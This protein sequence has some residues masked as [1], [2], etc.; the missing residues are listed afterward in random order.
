[1]QGR[2]EI[3][4]RIPLKCFYKVNY[5]K[6]YNELYFLFT[7]YNP[8]ARSTIT[9]KTLPD[10]H[11][12]MKKKI[13]NMLSQQ[14]SVSLT[15]DIWSDRTMRSYLGIAA[16]FAR[17][18]VTQPAGKKKLSSLLL[19]CRRFLGSHAGESIGW[20]SKKRWRNLK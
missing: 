6:E 5:F 17:K 13:L 2:Y 4:K 9:K 19:K 14:K 10:M 1:M 12:T 8:I 3:L 11:E 15:V 20:L 7:R 18:E 16:H